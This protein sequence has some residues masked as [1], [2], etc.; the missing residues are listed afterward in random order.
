[1]SA[2]HGGSLWGHARRRW[3]FCGESEVLASFAS[4]TFILSLEAAARYV[5]PLKHPHIALV[6]LTSECGI[7]VADV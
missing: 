3:A 2:V 5:E 7:T 6:Y 1:M 4:Y